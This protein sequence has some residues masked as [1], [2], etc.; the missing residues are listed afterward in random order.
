MKKNLIL[1][2]SALFVFAVA[3]AVVLTGCAKKEEVVIE[4]LEK[5]TAEIAE[6]EFR[7]FNLYTDKQAASPNFLD[8]LGTISDIEN[9][10]LE[11]LAHL[12]RAFG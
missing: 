2:L 5:P 7:V 12:S 10:L 8:V 4:E 9:F 3:T 11:N 1:T 6:R